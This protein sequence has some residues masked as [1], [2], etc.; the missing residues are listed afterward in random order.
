MT[1]FIM[2]AG[3]RLQ[4]AYSNSMTKLKAIEFVGAPFIVLQEDSTLHTVK[5]WI[6]L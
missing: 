3:D 4:L 1:D 5:K 6:Y 2:L